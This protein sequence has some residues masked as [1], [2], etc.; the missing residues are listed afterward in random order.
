MGR[1]STR[2]PRRQGGLRGGQRRARLRPRPP[3]VRRAR[4]RAGADRQHPARGADGRRGGGGRVRR[5]GPAAGASR[6]VTASASTPRWSSPARSRFADAV[7]IVRQRG[8]FMQEAVPVGTGAMAAIMGSS[9]R[10]SSTCAPTRRAGRGGR[11]R[12]RE[13]VACRSSSPGHRAAVERGG[14]AG[15]GAGRPEERAAAGERALPLLAHGAGRRAPRRAS[16]TPSTIADPDDAG[17]PQRRRAASR[18]RRR[19]CGRSCCARSPARSGG[20]TCVR[21]LADEGATTFVEVGP[22]RVLTRPAQAHRRRTR[23]AHS[24]EDPA[25]PRQGAGGRRWRGAA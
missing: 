5:A 18:E 6:P 1:A 20:R 7:R 13:L 11:G 4:V 24:V 23:A 8:E 19:T 15:Q 10:R 21:R 3:H 17:R 16:S 25:G 2:R 22:G 12:Q 9:C 14:G